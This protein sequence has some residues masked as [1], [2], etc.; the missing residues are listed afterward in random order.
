MIPRA[1][2]D[3]SDSKLAHS[4]SA[5]MSTIYISHSHVTRCHV[6]RCWDQQILYCYRVCSRT[7]RLIARLCGHGKFVWHV[8][9][10][11]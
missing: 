3:L 11:Y 1:V 2:Q 6:T 9:Y 7:I 10:F 8:A 4:W 5:S